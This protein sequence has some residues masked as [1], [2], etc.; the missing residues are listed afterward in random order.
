AIVS[1]V[2]SHL[3][4]A[5][6]IYVG[7]WV[8]YAFGQLVDDIHAMRHT[9]RMQEQREQNS[10]YKQTIQT[11]VEKQSSMTANPT[12]LS[13]KQEKPTV[14]KAILQEEILTVNTEEKSA[15]ISVEERN[16]EDKQVVLPKK[17]YIPNDRPN[18]ICEKCGTRNQ[19]SLLVCKKCLTHI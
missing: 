9:Q 18:W 16:A 12:P 5:T 2:F 1:S 19:G 17:P 8:L 13:N 14:A 10:M 4:T 6:A 7:S 11:N 3:I 15:E